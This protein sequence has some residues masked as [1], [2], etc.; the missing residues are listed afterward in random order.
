MSVLGT[1]AT[2]LVKPA[3]DLISEFITDKDKA[4]EIAYN[5]ARLA[6]DRHAESMKMQVEL[7][8]IDAASGKWWQAGW[9]PFFGWACGIAF[10]NN[11]VLMVWVQ[12]FGVEIA[13]MDWA[14]MSP[15]VMG[16]LG[17]G[18]LRTGEKIK[19]RS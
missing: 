6:G 12:A 1:F 3:A 14:A 16:M 18:T 17:L 2:A 9:R 8:K 15:V 11:F 13:P 4:N 10:L 5:L 19:G 7:N